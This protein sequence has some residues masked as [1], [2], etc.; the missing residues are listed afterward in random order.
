[1]TDRIC[2]GR[3]KENVDLSSS[4]EVTFIEKHKWDCGWYWAFGYV[5]NRNCHYHFESMMS[6][7]MRGT[8]Y[9]PLFLASEIFAVTNISDKEWWVIR[10]LFV[11]AYA[12]KKAAAVYR[13]G[14]HQSSQTGVTDLI[15]N[16]DKAASLNADLKLILDRLWDYMVEAVKPK[17]AAQPETEIQK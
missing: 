14:G 7:L 5:G 13:Y 2:L 12:L 11:Q 9:P 6:P 1:M 17:T 10:D 8:T 15:K 4:G 16:A 3:L